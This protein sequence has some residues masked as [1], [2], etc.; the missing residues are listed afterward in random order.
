MVAPS[1]LRVNT[2][3]SNA[4]W[5]IRASTYSSLGGLGNKIMVL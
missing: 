1:A 4:S 5:E 2:L 3:P